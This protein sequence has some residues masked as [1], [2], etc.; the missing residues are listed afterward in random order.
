MTNAHSFRSL[1]KKKSMAV[2]MAA[3]DPLGAK[4]VEEA[5]FDAVWGSGFE[6]SASFGV[7]DAS[8]ITMTDQIETTR[9]MV[10]TVRIPVIADFDTGF[11]NAINVHHA[12]RRYATAGISA[13]VIEDKTYPKDTSLREGGRQQLVRIE[14]FQGKIEAAV[15]AGGEEGIVIIARVEALIAGLGIEE[16]L[17]RA[18]AYCDAGADMILIHSKAK[19]PYEIETFVGR[20]DGRRPIVIVPTAYPEFDEARAAATGKIGLV[21]YGNHGLRAAVAAMRQ[22]FAQIRADGGAAAVDSRIAT[23]KEIM[24]LQGD[25]AMRELEKRFLR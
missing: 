19:T 6:L 5:G 20:W 15:S 2:A 21:I 13:L 3:H 24:E 7:P 25:A 17:A 23:V 8:L 12:V 22:T 4:L 1:L 18:A 14:E 9:R 16:A 10:E 11:G